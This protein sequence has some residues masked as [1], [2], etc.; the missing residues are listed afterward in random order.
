METIFKKHNP[1]APFEYRFVDEQYASKFSNEIKIGKL[2][3]FFAALAIFISCL[4]L[5]GLASYVA[6]QR[7]REIG[8]RKVLGASVFSVW[9]LLSKDFVVL[10]VISMF[11]AAPLGWYFMNSWL[12]NYV[13]RITITWRI[14]G[15][16]GFLVMML[17]IVM[18]SYQ[19]IKV[20][21][22]NPVKS[23]RAE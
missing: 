21:L 23:L 2:A 14:F 3:G 9:R 16:T 22:T 20:A 4:G 18:V 1:A 17:T 15:L 11:I 7:T 10:V 6:E 12:E 5:F 8:V 13:Y 19:S